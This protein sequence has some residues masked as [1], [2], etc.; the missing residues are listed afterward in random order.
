MKLKSDQ[1]ELRGALSRKE[2]PMDI[3]PLKVDESKNVLLDIRKI[4]DYLLELKKEIYKAVDVGYDD[5]SCLQELGNKT[6]MHC[7]H[8]IPS[9]FFE[10]V[11]TFQTF[12]EQGKSHKNRKQTFI[13][14]GI[15]INEMDMKIKLDADQQFLYDVGKMIAAINSS[16]S[17]LN[18]VESLINRGH[19]EE[20][21]GATAIISEYIDAVLQSARE[22]PFI[23][24]VPNQDKIKKFPSSISEAITS[25]LSWLKNLWKSDRDIQ[26]EKCEEMQDKYSSKPEL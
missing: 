24:L 11:Y 1:L 21:S 15:M 3:Q 8:E 18:R 25:L 10:A 17:Q 26:K 12:D 4:S 14:T 19:Y 6:N 2:D 22:A 23:E 20:A 5:V 16:L 9:E 7:F 13:D